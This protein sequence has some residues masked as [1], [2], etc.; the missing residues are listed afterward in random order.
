MKILGCFKVV[1][2]LELLSETDWS[3]PD[4]T[5]LDTDFVRTV[6]NCYDE[7]GLELML[8]AAE[9]APVSLTGLTMGRAKCNSY[10]KTLYALGFE[11]NVRIDTDADLRFV[12][13]W[14]AGCL[15]AYTRQ[16]PDIQVLVT[17]AQSADGC[18]AL[19][20]LIVAEQLHWP[21]ITQVTGFDVVHEHT[22]RV[23]N[24]T[25]EGTAVRT[26]SA[27]VVLAVGNAPQTF[28]RIPTLKAVMTLGKQPITLLTPEELGVAFP[29]RSAE[30]YR[31]APPDTKR[32]G[33]ILP[34]ATPAAQ[35][36][37]FYET[38]WKEWN[39]S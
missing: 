6:W 27:P 9:C 33:V 30:L 11:E 10:L 29:E 4:D 1:P 19:T 23:Q 24:L 38:F 21:C 31:L 39:R 34:G 20:P 26:L 2:D 18:N 32:A 36:E 37:A 14:V 7:S 22:L 5:C 3:C 15:A 25:D 13:E 28:L 35:V 16:H 12:P 17:G 8:R